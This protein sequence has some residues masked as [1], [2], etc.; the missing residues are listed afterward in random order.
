MQNASVPLVR[1]LRQKGRARSA[2][3]GPLADS[4]S[5]L[6]HCE[7]LSPFA[8][9]LA[10]EMPGRS[11]SVPVPPEAQAEADAG[12]AAGAES[13]PCAPQADTDADAGDA[14]STDTEERSAREALAADEA[15][16]ADRGDLRFF[17]LLLPPP[18]P[19]LERDELLCLL[20]RRLLFPFGVAF[21]PVARFGS[22]ALAAPVLPAEP[23][24]PLSPIAAVAPPPTPPPLPLSRELG[25]GESAD[26]V[27]S[28]GEEAT[29]EETF[30][31]PPAGAR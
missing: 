3:G 18:F 6:V 10:L 7:P 29:D 25:S 1:Q 26:A 23:L 13:T 5:S 16:V 2:S 20:A 22:L 15:A 9:A 12:R 30:E 24:P 14:E 28:A 4:E 17:E 11:A 21:A 31:A 19:P 8:F 27:P